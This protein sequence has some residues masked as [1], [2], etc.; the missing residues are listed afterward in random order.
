[1]RV[2]TFHPALAMAAGAVLLFAGPTS[3]SGAEPSG[4][5]TFERDIQPIL[6][7]AGCNA[8]ACHGKAGGQNGFQLSILG[9]DPASD[10]N[11]I[12][13]D[14]GGRRVLRTV[15]EDSLVL[16]KATAEVPHGG[17]RRIDPSSE[18]YQTFRQWIAAGYPRTPADAP[19]LESVTVEP[20]EM[21][22]RPDE[23]FDLRVTARFSDG[24][25]EDV[26]RLAVF[27]STESTAVAV[28]EEGRVKAGKFAGEATIS[29]RYEGN[30]ANCGVLIPLEGEVDAKAYEN[31]PRA[32]FI[33]GHVWN[34]LQKLG[35]TPSAP[36][37][38][39]TFLRRAFL[40]VIGRLPTADET[41]E[42]LDDQAPD[43]RAKL[44]DRLLERPEYA[45]FWA[46]KW[47][48]LLRPNPYRV[49]IKAVFNLDG[50]I[51][52][53]FRRN[54][55]YDQF[56]REIVA[57]KG[58]TFEQGPATIFRDH[59]DPIEVS[60]V[61]SQL[62]LGI[63]LDCAK[64]HHHPF[65]T[66]SQKQFYEFS[67]YFSR[68][69]RKGVG[70]SPPISG[71]EEMVFAAKSGVIKDPLTGEVLPPKPL[72]GDAPPADD[73]DVDPREILAEWITSTKN[74]YFSEVIV[75]R[76]WADLMGAGIV[77][78]IDDIRATNP[79]SNAPLLEALAD[80]FR[81]NGH[82]LKHLIRTIMASNVYGLSSEPNDRNVADTRNFSRHYRQRLRAEVLLDAVVDVTGAPESFAAAPPLT[83]ATTLWTNRVPSLFLDTFGRPDA[84]QDPPCE[85]L[86]DAA[87][88]QALH[89]MNA[90][91]LQQKL[92]SD[93]GRAAELAKS[94]KAPAAIV[95][96]LYLTCYNR[97]PSQDERSVAETLFAE[98]K[99]DRRGAVEDLLWA[100]LNSPEFVFKD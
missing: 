46:N 91:D 70:L 88:V 44:V 55:P 33:D 100:L 76:V 35:L 42:F 7:R 68:V 71:S 49:G 59:R 57:A 9:Y 97:L 62:F 82:D 22:L 69:G 29:A 75:N 39:S 53:Q 74:D 58:S 40:D 99:D 36:A 60:P 48:D 87:V 73:P 32:N 16:Q 83:R 43:K 5:V 17:G 6:T 12:A 64:C 15:P 47:M 50:W 56:V 38:D 93:A 51:R 1:M 13:R 52:D 4:V 21:R 65:E 54:V 10:F 11:A 26:T 25:T 19:T 78:P 61:V 84:N 28:N 2:A 37:S 63:R 66:W 89:L 86:E 77:D 8:G 90:P 94:D 92:S 72:F 30:F 27:N 41:R 98:R 18:F 45:D 3:G 67:A 85:R 23:T 81:K 95:D 31:L 24:T 14:D 96:E 80:D 79:P 34:K 20:T